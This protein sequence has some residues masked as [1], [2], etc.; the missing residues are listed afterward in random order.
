MAEI[1]Y[2]SEQGCTNFPKL[3]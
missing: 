1:L 2:V 3:Y